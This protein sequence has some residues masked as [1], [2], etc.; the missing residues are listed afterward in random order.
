LCFLCRAIDMNATLEG[1]SH[2]A[3]EGDE[4]LG[5]LQNLITADIENQPASSASGAALLTP[6]GKIL[7]DFIVL[8]DIGENMILECRTEVAAD[9]AQRL[10]F[11][12]LRAKL[13]I[14]APQPVLI[15]ISDG[16]GTWRDLRFGV[17]VWRSIA[18]ANTGSRTDYD[19]L[20]IR[21]GVSESGADY[22]LGEAFPHDVNLDQ[23][24]AV[25]MRKGCYVGQEV[26]SRMQ[27]RGTARRRLVIA[28]G[29]GPLG[30]A[31]APVLVEGREI[32]TLGTISGNHAL[33]IIRL[34]KI[35][36][37]G[38]PA[39]AG[40][41]EVNFDLPQ[42]ATFSLKPEAEPHG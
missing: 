41:V 14:G 16:L 24:G 17:P 33:A 30:V 39:M 32:G 37:A 28:N 20:R 6:Q 11:Y 38:F 23:I 31:G 34:D 9:L 42:G 2:I 8:K 15:H 40:G 29:A 26:V 27:H 25:G 10:T 1:L 7:F 3:I 18:D 4:A 13:S 22:A 21:H 35:G 12:K 19:N 5:W 36:G